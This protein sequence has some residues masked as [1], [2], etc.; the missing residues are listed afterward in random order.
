MK[1]IPQYL[2]HLVLKIKR[3]LTRTWRDG[4]ASARLVLVKLARSN[5]KKKDHQG[6]A[7]FGSPRSTVMVWRGTQGWTM[8]VIGETPGDVLG[9][10]VH[11]VLDCDVFKSSRSGY[12]TRGVRRC[13]L[14][15]T[16]NASSIVSEE[17][18]SCLW[19]SE[20]Q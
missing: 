11:D 4:P 9:E 5:S 2:L 16:N 20:P 18:R 7:F 6:R 8:G 3:R 19:F 12:S 15:P 13:V 14:M 17:E 10:F 1:Y